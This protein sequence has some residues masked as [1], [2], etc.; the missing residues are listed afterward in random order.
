MP[1]IAV[2][3]NGNAEVTQDK[4]AGREIAGMFIENSAEDLQELRD[5]QSGLVPF[6]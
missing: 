3:K 1:E 2:H 4:I 5:Q 6:P